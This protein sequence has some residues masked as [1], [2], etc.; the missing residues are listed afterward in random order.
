MYV[1]NYDF[2][3]YII[4]NIYL[5]HHNLFYYGYIYMAFQIFFNLS[6]LYIN[7]IAIFFSNFFG[8]IYIDLI[9]CFLLQLLLLMISFKF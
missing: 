5:Q 2:V 3:I 8:Y 6:N 1:L 9:S 7:I 4:A